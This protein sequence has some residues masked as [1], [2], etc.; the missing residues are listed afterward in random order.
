M[1]RPS[2]SGFI[3]VTY[4]RGPGKWKASVWDASTQK[5]RSGGYHATAEGAARAYDALAFSIRG[6]AG[7]LNFPA[8]Y[9][10]RQWPEPKPAGDVRQA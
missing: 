5:I 8:E 7:P 10:G 1:G 6:W 4:C 3:G 9:K 2:S